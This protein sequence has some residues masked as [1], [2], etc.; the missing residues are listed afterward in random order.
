MVYSVC[1]VNELH[2]VSVPDDPKAIPIHSTSIT[3]LS[4]VLVDIL[5]EDGAKTD[6]SRVARGS[7]L[8]RLGNP[9]KASFFASVY[10]SK[11]DVACC[12]FFSSLSF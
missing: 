10:Y 2:F 11:L 12:C 8:T 1:I 4:R 6:E 7:G 5:V 3:M 9:A